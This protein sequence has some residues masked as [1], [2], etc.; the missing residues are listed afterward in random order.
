MTFQN[1]SADVTEAQV[2]GESD[3]NVTVELTEE[4]IDVQQN[5]SSSGNETAP[6][7]ET[8]SDNETAPA[9][10]TSS[11]NDSGNQ[12]ALAS[13]SARS[14]ASE[15]RPTPADALPAREDT[16]PARVGLVGAWAGALLLA[17]RD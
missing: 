7:N 10:D 17:G 2:I 4:S 9:N 1:A 11:G 8:A 16:A 13:P 14:D 5:Q 15:S 6:G 12:S 3:Q